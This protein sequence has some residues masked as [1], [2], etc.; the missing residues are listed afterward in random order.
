M[1]SVLRASVFLNLYTVTHAPTKKQS[2]RTALIGFVRAFIQKPVI[3][4]R[5][6]LGCSNICH[7]SLF[8]YLELF[9]ASHKFCR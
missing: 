7:F 9:R 4:K 6:M 3:L 5:C 2:R 8:N 1:L